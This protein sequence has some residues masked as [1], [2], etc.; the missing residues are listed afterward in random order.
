MNGI[1]I[2]DKP[3][4]ITSFDVV[5]IMKKKFNTSKVGHTGTL[6][7]LAT[8]ILVICINSALKIAEKLTQDTKEYEAVI[9]LGMQTDTLDITGNII[10][11]SNIPKLTPIKVNQVLEKFTGVIN[12]VVPLY[13]SIKINGKK[14]YEYARNNEVITP[15]T[16]KVLIE[17]INLIEIK[18]DTIKIKC[19]VSKGTYI[20]SLA[21]D[22]GLSLGTHGTIKNLRRIKQGNFSIADA[23]TLEQIEKDYFKI[24]SIENA[25][26][27]KTID[28]S[29]E[30][31]F[32]IKNGQIINNFTK[33]A[34]I[35]FTY[36]HQPVAIYQTYQKDIKK[37]KPW[38][39]F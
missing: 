35:L 16:R 8:G 33:E 19:K 18:E 21:R 39:V 23:F 26:N 3:S 13:S 14:L 30:L 6:D 27:I 20:R 31:Y 24:I 28:V 7:P 15:P 36:Q 29:K 37:I 10:T 5:K 38:K 1:I 12:Q 25:L 11:T 22:I 32:K 2:V 17:Y 9:K 4:G 34:E